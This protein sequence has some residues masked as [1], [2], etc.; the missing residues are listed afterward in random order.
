MSVSLNKYVS[1]TGRCSRREA[2]R[3]IEAGRLAI[4]GTT[5]VKGNRVEKGDQVTVD[6]QP[7]GGK[8]APVYLV[9]HKP[10]G[11]TSTTDRK[12][13]DN[14]VDFIRYPQRIFPVGRLD[15]ASTGLLLM[16]NDGDIVNEILR[17]EYE[18]EKEYVVSVHKPLTESFLRR[19]SGGIP[20]LGTRTKDCTVEQLDVRV[21]RIVL[22]QGLNRQIRRMCDFLGY[23]VTTLKRVRIMNIELGDLPVG[24]YRE[25][26]GEELQSLLEEVG[27]A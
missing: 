4:N 23:R 16:T 22:V 19:M 26:E 11:I 17:A 2:D 25:L 7:L 5:A 20:I 9:L 15:K 21:F 3:W 10:A 18:H 14:L 8:P 24:E 6:G 1:A 13:R 27:R 12:D